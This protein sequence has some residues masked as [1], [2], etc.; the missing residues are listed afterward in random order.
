MG[1][2]RL[3]RAVRDWLSML[4]DRPL[5]MVFDAYGNWADEE[6]LGIKERRNKSDFK[7]DMVAALR[8][9]GSAVASGRPPPGP[10]S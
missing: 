8:A 3:H 9:R 1:R 2:F 10:A 6:L 5:A 4:D 7:N